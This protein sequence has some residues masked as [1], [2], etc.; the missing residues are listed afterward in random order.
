[1]EDSERKALSEEEIVEEREPAT[2]APEAE[3]AVSEPQKPKPP[4]F[5]W[6]ATLWLPLVMLVSEGCFALLVGNPLS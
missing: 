2:E 3:A 4:V 5:G 6:L 1:M